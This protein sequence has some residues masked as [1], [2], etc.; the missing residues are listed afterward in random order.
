MN[1]PRVS[2]FDIV[3]KVRCEAKAGLDRFKDTRHADH[4]RQIIEATSIGYDF[5]F[6]MVEDNDL[7]AGQLDFIGRPSNRA[8]KRS[9]TVNLT[10]AA[11]KRRENTRTFRIVEDL[12]DVAKADCSDEFLRANL[13]Y[14]ITGSLRV[15]DIVYT[16]VRLERMSNLGDPED[17]ADLS[18]VAQDDTKKGVFSEHLEFRTALRLGA[19]PTLTISAVAGSFRLT[20]ATVNGQVRRNDTHDV[21]IAFAQDPAFHKKEVKRAVAQRRS[22][23]KP[24]AGA[25][26]RFAAEGGLAAKRFV[27]DPRSET[28]LAQANARARTRVLLE[29]TRLRNL[30][31]DE[32]ESPKFLGERLLTFLRPPNETRRGD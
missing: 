8:S 21:I 25:D 6:T 19:T 4:V 22:F 24:V 16:Y 5:H 13:A 26:A 12:A 20:N 9:V 3:Q 7:T 18:D 1:F 29:L 31:D 28:A 27:M 11:Q 14:P 32:Q 2:T 30:K 10:G 15:D 23:L 17:P